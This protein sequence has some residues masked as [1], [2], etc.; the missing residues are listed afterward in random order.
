M[1]HRPHLVV[2]RYGPPLLRP[3]DAPIVAVVFRAR[4]RTH[5]LTVARALRRRVGRA[6]WIVE[7]KA[8]AHIP[9]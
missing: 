5:A 7:Q 8:P 6:L 3:A 9:R 1:T 4:H 2:M